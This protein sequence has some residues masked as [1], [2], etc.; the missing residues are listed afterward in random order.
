MDFF[1][2]PPTRGARQMGYVV[3]GFHPNEGLDLESRTGQER[4]NKPNLTRYS[5]YL[6]VVDVRR[7][8]VI[9]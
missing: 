4:P 8:D 1:C 5:R 9:D 6:A 7:G 3:G 2:S